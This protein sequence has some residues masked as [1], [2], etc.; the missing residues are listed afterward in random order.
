MNKTVKL[1]APGGTGTNI[2]GMLMQK[3]D[4]NNLNVKLETAVID[5][6]DSNLKKFPELQDNVFMVKTKKDTGGSGKVRGENG[7]EIIRSIKPFLLENPPCDYNI[8]VFNA[9]G[10]S[11]SVAGPEI[12][13]ELLAQECDVIGIIIEDDA[14]VQG[15]ENCVKTLQTFENIV[16]SLES[17]VVISYHKNGPNFVKVNEAAIIS[18]TALLH[19]FSGEN[20]GLDT[21]DIKHWLRPSLVSDYDPSLYSLRIS[22][23]Q[24][25][26]EEKI[27]NPVAV[28]SI[29]KNMEVTRLSTFIEYSTF[30]YA[31]LSEL[32]PD[33]D[34]IHFAVTSEGM[35]AHIDNL[36]ERLETA[37]KKADARRASKRG[38]SKL[39]GIGKGVNSSSAT[40]F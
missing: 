11:G 36:I 30:G 24:E 2:V 34:Q 18:I 32:G 22:L 40:V 33:T 12:I 10:G 35:D 3:Y 26:F 14:D 6:S 15:I 9:A 16:E 31:D 13:S 28:A 8:V 1:Y 38:S 37:N 21:R 4:L 23:G 5:T 17:D 19:L 39:S 27:L 20:D 29:Y 7:E 25:K